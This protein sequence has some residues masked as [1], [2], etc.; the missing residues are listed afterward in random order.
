[1]LVESTGVALGVLGLS[2]LAEGAAFLFA[3]K[4]IRQDA[5]REGVTLFKYLL[6]VWH[7]L[8]SGYTCTYTHYTH[9]H[10]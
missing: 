3:L 7:T 6:T 9:T 2:F 1:M 5:R 10:T 8:I 4:G